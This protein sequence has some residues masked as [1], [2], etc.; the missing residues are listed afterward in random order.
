MDITQIHSTNLRWNCSGRERKLDLRG[1]GE[2]KSEGREVLEA[3]RDKQKRIVIARWRCLPSAVLVVR[4]EFGTL[5][6]VP[7]VVTSRLR[8]PESTCGHLPGE[9]LIDLRIG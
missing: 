6:D 5:G 3:H 8:R 9:Q 7:A 2:A 4:Q 1:T